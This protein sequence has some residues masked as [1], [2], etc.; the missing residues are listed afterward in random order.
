MPN[1]QLQATDRLYVGPAFTTLLQGG[2]VA[3]SGNTAILG[4]TTYNY[5]GFREAGA[6]WLYD[7]ADLYNIT[8]I[9]LTA[10]D[11]EEYLQFGSAVAISDNM[12]LVGCEFGS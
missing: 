11:A 12:A 6:A 5:S 9:R 7:L 2:S 10:S 4:Y 8:E 3:T 1:K